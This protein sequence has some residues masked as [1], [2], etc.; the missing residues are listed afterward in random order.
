MGEGYFEEEGLV[1]Q[2]QS[3]N[4]SSQVIQALLAGQAQL[5]HPGPGPLLNAREG[6]EDLVYIYNYFTRSQFNLVAA[7]KKSSYQSP[8]DL[9]GKV[10]GVGT[11][12]GA[13]VT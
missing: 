3:V 13:E 8:T 10:I 9:K 4:G 7:R 5:G 11:S 6:G 2:P 1:I 12:D